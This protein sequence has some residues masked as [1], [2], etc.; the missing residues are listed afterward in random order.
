MRS[1]FTPALAA[2]CIE[3]GP[4]GGAFLV[5]Y[6]KTGASLRVIASNGDGWDHVSVSLEHRCPN[7]HEMDFI[8]RLFF[9]EDEWAMQLHPPPAKHINLHPYVLHL[10]RPQHETIPLPEP[11]AV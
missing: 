3:R 8:K 6:P 11:K 7:W 4:D 9:A 10:W 5:P 1:F 2:L